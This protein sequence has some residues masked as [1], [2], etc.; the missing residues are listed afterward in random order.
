MTAY[1]EAVRNDLTEADAAQTMG[2][3]GKWGSTV[4]E[5]FRSAG[6][7]R[8]LELWLRIQGRELY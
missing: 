8:E 7:A 2:I 4:R 1:S 3:R 6:F 5:G